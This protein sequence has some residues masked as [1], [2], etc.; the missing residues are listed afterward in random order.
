MPSDREIVFGV[1]MWNLCGVRPRWLRL[2]DP[3]PRD[4]RP[5]GK[6]G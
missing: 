4:G 6:C 5:S 3:A 2:P 1:K